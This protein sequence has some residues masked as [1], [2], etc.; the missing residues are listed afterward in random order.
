M[1]DCAGFVWL[2][3]DRKLG[4][5][6][7]RVHGTGRHLHGIPADLFAGAVCRCGPVPV[8]EVRG[9]ACGIGF[10]GED[11]R[12]PDDHG[13]EYRSSAHERDQTGHDEQVRPAG[14]RGG[15][16]AP[17]PHLPVRGAGALGV[18]G[19]RGGHSQEVQGVRDDAEVGPAA[20]G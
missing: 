12:E 2:H 3:P 13:G 16:A 6:C 14:R 4:K 5:D 1:F 15:A 10:R 11:V 17:R 9:A 18:P 8:R 19:G 7:Y 20:A